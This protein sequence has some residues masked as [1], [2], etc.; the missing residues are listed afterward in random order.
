MPE[1]PPSVE[2]GVT[3]TGTVPAT[4][5]QTGRRRRPTGTPAPLPR[6]LGFTGRTWLIG[7]L[8]LLGWVVACALFRPARRVTDQVDAA[9]LRGISTIRTGWLTNVLTEIDQWFSGWTVTVVGVGLLVAL[10]VF[11][12][13]RHLF[14]LLGGVLLVEFVGGNILYDGFTRPRPYDVTI[15]GRW[16]GYSLP[17]PPV[18]IVTML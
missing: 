13:W 1:Y 15:I 4:V 5:R 6:S 10:M 16:A 9:I 2:H 11:K 12:R 18:A 3:R 7:T 14:T 8:V 17:S